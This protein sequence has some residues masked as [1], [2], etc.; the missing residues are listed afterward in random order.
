MQLLE[1]LMRHS[2]LLIFLRHKGVGLPSRQSLL[3]LWL[4]ILYVVVN[5]Q[6]ELLV[7]QEPNKYVG[8][9]GLMVSLLCITI[10][11]P[12]PAYIILLSYL[13]SRIIGGVGIVVMPEIGTSLYLLTTLW[14]YVAAL[15]GLMR[16]GTYQAAIRKNSRKHRHLNA[17]RSA[18]KTADTDS[19]TEDTS[20]DAENKG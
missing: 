11:R 4:A 17:V 9:G 14:G 7:Q 13:G 18:N 12:T 6:V 19:P 8:L 10:F 5:Y 15:L 3:L 20:Q 2:Y 16:F 1:A